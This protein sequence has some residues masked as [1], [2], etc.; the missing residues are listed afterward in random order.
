VVALL[1]ISTSSSASVRAADKWLSVRRIAL[2]I[3]DPELDAAL[4]TALVGRTDLVADEG[5]PDVVVSDTADHRIM[6]RG[7]LGETVLDSLEPAL[8]LSAAALV[9]AGYR[10]SAERDAPRIAP[11]TA[12]ELQVASLL[13]EG[14]PNKAIA[15]ALGISVHTV[16]FHVAAVLAKLGARNR[17]DAVAIA[18]RE[19]LVTL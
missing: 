12:R 8:I 19:G 1:E 11:L 17:A 2:A 16:K 10:V 7:A 15:R 13:V 9:A 18:L 6:L 3:T 5:D 4:R 14:A